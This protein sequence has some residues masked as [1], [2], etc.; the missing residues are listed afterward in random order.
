[1]GRP[2]GS[3]NKSTKAPKVR[4]KGGPRG[5]KKLVAVEGEIEFKEICACEKWMQQN[6]KS[7]GGRCEQ[8]GQDGYWLMP[9][10][11]GVLRYMFGVKKL[12]AMDIK[13]LRQKAAKVAERNIE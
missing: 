1:M 13:K 10:G 3:K 12:T 9:D 2:K 11:S 8:I 4:V 5:R 7:K 6:V